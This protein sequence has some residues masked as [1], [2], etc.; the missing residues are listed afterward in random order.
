MYSQL[1]CCAEREGAACENFL[2]LS[3]KRNEE[4]E[5]W[6]ALARRTVRWRRILRVAGG[7]LRHQGAGT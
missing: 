7:Q 5:S 3:A 6:R 1:M 2:S 4:S